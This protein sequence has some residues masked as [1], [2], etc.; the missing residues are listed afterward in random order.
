MAKN[1]GRSTAK[2]E[3]EGARGLVLTA[4]Q[5]YLGEICSFPHGEKHRFVFWAGCPFGPRTRRSRAVVFGSGFRRF[6]P[7][8]PRIT[9]RLQDGFAGPNW[10]Q[11]GGLGR[12]QEAK[13][14]PRSMPVAPCPGWSRSTPPK[15]PEAWANAVTAEGRGLQE[16]SMRGGW[17]GGQHLLAI[18]GSP[19]HRVSLQCLYVPGQVGVFVPELLEPEWCLSRLPIVVGFA[20]TSPLPSGILP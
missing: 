7:G 3:R 6:G 17:P 10:G 16:R 15:S 14:S 19:H 18:P 1:E 11:G 4:F 20:G 8:Q 2:K 5:R 9:A 12:V 13:N